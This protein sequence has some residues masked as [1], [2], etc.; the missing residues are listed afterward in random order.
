M[1]LMKSKK[2]VDNSLATWEFLSGVSV[3]TSIVL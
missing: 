2:L 1:K 3:R